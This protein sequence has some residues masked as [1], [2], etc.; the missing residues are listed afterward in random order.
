MKLPR[1]TLIK[2]DDSFSVYE[3]V[4]EGPKGNIHKLVK[5][6]E[7]NIPGVF[8]LAFGDKDENGDDIDD[9]V[10]SNNGNSEK[11]LAT[12]VATVYAFSEQ[13]PDCFI[14]AAGS[15]KARTRL[16]RM[17]ISRYLDEIKN[18]FE[19][20]GLKEGQWH[21]FEKGTEFDAFLVKRLKK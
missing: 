5:F 10:V 18:D 4:S 15:T 16:Y 13:Y 2:A 14:Y 19:V 9:T 12:V 6:A 1:Y 7:T 17:G 8:N 20:Y 3:F 11:V 21:F